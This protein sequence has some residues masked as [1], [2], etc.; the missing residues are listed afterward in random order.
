INNYQNNFLS[1]S[2]KKLAMEEDLREKFLEKNIIKIQEIK[3]YLNLLSNIVT[4]FSQKGSRMILTRP[5]SMLK[6]QINTMFNEL[7]KKKNCSGLE[8]QEK[9][10]TSKK[11]IILKNFLSRI[12]KI[13]KQ[14]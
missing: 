3:E 8:M 13:K 5:L 4:T 2:N 14:N 1:H 10:T 12:F 7:S 6:S 11:V 9:K